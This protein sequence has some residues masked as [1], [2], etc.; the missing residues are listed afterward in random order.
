M[1]PARVYSISTST[2]FYLNI[3]QTAVAGTA[4]TTTGGDPTIFATRIA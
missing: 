1:I 4:G 2:V 3:R